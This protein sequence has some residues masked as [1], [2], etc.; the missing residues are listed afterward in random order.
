LLDIRLICDL[1]FAIG[2][3]IFAPSLLCSIRK[4]VKMPVGTTLPTA[5]VL[6]VFVGGYA[7]MG[8]NLAAVSTAL[9]AAC[10]WILYARR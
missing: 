9:T 5:A 10:W 1:I 7:L 2:G 3:F 8:L 4:R 6:T